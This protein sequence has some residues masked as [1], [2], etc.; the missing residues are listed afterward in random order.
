MSAPMAAAAVRL[1]LHRLHCT[2]NFASSD[3]NEFYTSTYGGEC[4]GGDD[5]TSNQSDLHAPKFAQ[6][7]PTSTN[8]LGG[9]GLVIITGRGVHSADGSTRVR[10]AAESVLTEA[11]LGLEEI[12]EDKAATFG[13]IASEDTSS[14][15]I[16]TAVTTQPAWRRAQDLSTAVVNEGALWVTYA[17]VVAWLALEPEEVSRRLWGGSG[18]ST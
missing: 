2:N 15:S 4:A 14:A 13:G 17:A 1:T 3:Y 16:K 7:H 9:I 11:L 6:S 10:K 18:D 12:H 8:A 5:F